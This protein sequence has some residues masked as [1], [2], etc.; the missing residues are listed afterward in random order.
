MKKLILLLFCL[1][2]SHFLLA[3]GLKVGDFRVSISD[4]SASTHLRKDAN[5]QPC[6]LV[7]VQTKVQESCRRNQD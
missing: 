5:G 1:L 6:G 3:Q 7:K 2:S 4:L